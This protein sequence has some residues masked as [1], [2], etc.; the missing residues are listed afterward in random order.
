MSEKQK[1]YTVVMEVELPAPDNIGQGAY[2]T[3]VVERALERALEEEV[4]LDSF[5]VVQVLPG[6]RELEP[7]PN[8]LKFVIRRVR[9]QLTHLIR[10]YQPRTE[11][12]DGHLMIE[13]A[14]VL[15]DLDTLKI[16]A[17]RED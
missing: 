10:K 3:D 11:P 9:Q 17:D 12:F 15:E 1:K 4:H 13:V 2:V 16:L 14:E 7:Q 5:D 6:S 8:P